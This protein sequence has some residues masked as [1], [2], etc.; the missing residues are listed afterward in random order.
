MIPVA[1]VQEAAGNTPGGLM[2]AALMGEE[3]TQGLQ[4]LAQSDGTQL[5]G[6]DDMPLPAGGDGAGTVSA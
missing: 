3:E 1:I 6:A 5:D 2:I 4:D